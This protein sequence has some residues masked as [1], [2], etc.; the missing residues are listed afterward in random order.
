MVSR[1]DGGNLI[2][3]PPRE[4][5]DRSELTPAEL[6]QWSF[7]VAAT[8]RAITRRFAA[9]RRRMHQL[10][11]RGQLAAQPTGGATRSEEWARAPQA[12][13]APAGRSPTATDP[14]WRW[15]EAPNFPDFADRHTWA[16]KFER[17]NAEECRNI[18]ARAESL[19][20]ERYGVP[21]GDLTS[22]SPCAACGYPTLLEQG[23]T[24]ARCTECSQAA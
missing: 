1:L 11:G 7:L 4:V 20:R 9:A 17:L 24:G 8:A 18:V 21:A 3:L 10:L 19:L 23:T 22:W 12:A 13:H 14:S 2:V 6:T 15:G 5:W 16:E